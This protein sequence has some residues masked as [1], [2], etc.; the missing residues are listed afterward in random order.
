M[1]ALFLL[2]TLIASAAPS[3]SPVEPRQDSHITGGVQ[4][5]IPAAAKLGL[6][7]EETNYYWC[8][9]NLPE[10]EHHDENQFECTIFNPDGYALL[11]GNFIL[12]QTS[13]VKKDRLVKT[14]SEIE[15]LGYEGG[16]IHFIML[17]NGQSLKPLT[18]SVFVRDLTRLQMTFEN[19]KLV[20]MRDDGGVLL[21]KTTE[22]NRPT[23]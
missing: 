19:E 13:S 21:Q 9:R 6:G 8:F 23:E 18:I 12:E 11:N 16:G 7:A 3:V 5:K 20:K 22:T 14:Q 10:W 17:R 4:Y 15:K 2:T 1:V